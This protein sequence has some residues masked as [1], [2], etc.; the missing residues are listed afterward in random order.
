M[1]RA[2]RPRNRG[3]PF[4]WGRAAFIARAG[5][6]GPGMR[7][8]RSP[9]YWTS[10]TA[11]D[12]TADEVSPSPPSRAGGFVLAPERAQDRALVDPLI[13]RVFGPGR[14]VK[15][16][17]RLREANTFRPDLSFCAW[18]GDDLVAAV[19]LWPIEIG[20]A[21]AQFLGPL[22]VDPPH[23]GEGAGRALVARAC[24]AAAEAGEA[25]VLLVGAPA[26]FGP[27][28]FEAIP[29]GRVSLPG[30]VDPARLLW[31]GLRPGALDPVSGRARVPPG[32][33]GRA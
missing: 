26:Y 13:E 31:R 1:A 15:T 19:R 4:T 30:P 25:L 33:P 14:L 21:P 17:E 10:A 9:S 16:A 20:G 22:A 2:G 24:Q 11:A 5:M 32:P 23:Q 28:G 8:R 3:K 29:R 18:A 7:N 27:L 6:A 12:T